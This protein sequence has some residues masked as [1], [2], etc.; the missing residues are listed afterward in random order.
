MQILLSNSKHYPALILSPV[1]APSLKLFFALH[2]YMTRRKPG[3][4]I[5]Q[6]R[7]HWAGLTDG[8]PWAGL[9]WGGKPGSPREPG[10]G[11]TLFLRFVWCLTIRIT[12]ETIVR[13]HGFL[14]QPYYNR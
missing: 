11:F 10:P 2:V 4:F 1:A 7:V 9:G 14:Q 13:A 6:G 12:G 3:L 5:G 8:F